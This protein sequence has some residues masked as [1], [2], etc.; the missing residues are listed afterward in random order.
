MHTASGQLDL[1]SRREPIQE[2]LAD[3]SAEDELK[4]KL[5]TVLQISERLDL[6]PHLG[7]RAKLAS[8]GAGKWQ[9]SGGEKSK[10]GLTA[11]T[12]EA[13]T[14]EET[15]FVTVGGAALPAAGKLRV[16]FFYSFN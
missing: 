7:V 12:G 6:R 2:L 8:R 5:E 14:A 11:A 3:P 15:V 1:L 16:M 13:V 10:F 4:A 9:E